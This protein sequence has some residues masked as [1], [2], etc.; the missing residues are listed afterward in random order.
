MHLLRTLYS[1]ISTN[2]L[3][4][5]INFGGI[6]VKGRK[7]MKVESEKVKMIRKK[8]DKENLGTLLL[9]KVLRMM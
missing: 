5:I 9:D 6:L 1:I 2:N 8:D 4:E 3:N 7:G